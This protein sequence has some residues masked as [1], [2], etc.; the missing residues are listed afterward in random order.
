M[1]PISCYIITKN[2]SRKIKKVIESVSGLVNE[3]I[4]IDSGSTDKTLSIAKTLGAKVMF[5]KWD[6]YGKQ[7]RFG[8]QKR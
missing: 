2:E 3:I 6:G 8:H 4:I 7:K 5:N 1:L